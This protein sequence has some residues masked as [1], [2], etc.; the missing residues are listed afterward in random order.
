MHVASVP[1]S[2]GARPGLATTAK[3]LNVYPAFVCWSVCQQ[4]HV[5]TT[6]RIFMKILPEMC[7]SS[8]KK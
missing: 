7:L 8:G 6:A 4:S 3:E 5:K 1:S 2:G